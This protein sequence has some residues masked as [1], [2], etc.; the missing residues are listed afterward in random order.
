MQ[1]LSIVLISVLAFASAAVSSAD[2]PN[3][4]ELVEIANRY[5][6]PKPKQDAK[7]VLGFSGSWRSSDAGI[8]R[9]GFVTKNETKKK[10]RVLVGF[11]EM[12]CQE[13][14][15][16]PATRPY[17]LTSPDETK[18]GYSIEFGHLSNFETAVQLAMIDKKD[19]AKQ[20]W[21]R[22]S[23]AK[24]MSGGHPHEGINQ[25]RQTPNV[26]LAICIFK[27]IEAESL[28][29]GTN[30]VEYAERLE[31]LRNE[32]PSLFSKD[33]NN[34]TPYARDQFVEDLQ[35]TAKAMAPPAGSIE[36]LLV[37]WGNSD[38]EMRHLGYFSS[39][40]VVDDAPAREIFYRV[41]AVKNLLKLTKDRRLSVH[42][43]PAIM[44]SPPYRNRMGDLAENLLRQIS[45][46]HSTT[47]RVWPTKSHLEFS[48]NVTAKNSKH[49]VKRLGPRQQTKPIVTI[50]PILFATQR[51]RPLKKPDC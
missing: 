27:H 13:R 41:D 8:Y 40:N 48:T 18:D 47:K 19:D 42:V 3:F 9:P 43:Q 33:S 34:Y 14:K 44:N 45:K 23:Q 35:L 16:V 20:L 15:R 28:K 4:D 36:E 11:N 46:L 32:Y 10:V 38:G 5:K 30:F 17:T 25:L 31:K 39:H 12:I 6:L 7:P 22:F 2:T 1:T 37:R 51:C 50:S 26:L 49:F 24:F 21:K 29:P